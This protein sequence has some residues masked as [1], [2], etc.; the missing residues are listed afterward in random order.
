MG[1]IPEMQRWYNIRKSVNVIHHIKKTKEKPP[2][3][4]SIGADKAFGKVQHPFMTET[5]TKV[6][7][8]EHSST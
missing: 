5:L 1:F 8:M 6:G 2:I 7:M 4:I 3:I